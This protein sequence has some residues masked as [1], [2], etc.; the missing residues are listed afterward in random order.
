M[1]FTRY[2]SSM[3]GMIT[4]RPAVASDS[5]DLYEW[6]NDPDSRGA[7]GSQ[8]P[9]PRAE[10]DI[11]FSAAISSRDRIIY[12][13]VDSGSGASVGMCR[14]DIDRE[15]L[16]A[17]VSI[18]LDPAR[19]GAGL[20]YPI[21]DG[22]IARFRMD[23]GSALRLTATIRSTNKASARIFRKAGFVMMPSSSAPFDQYVLV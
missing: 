10:H 1:T 4:F 13:A 15:A 14:F 12:L 6:R 20:A 18:N 2:E 21:L 16:T 22:A 17:E 11:W 3:G 23:S 5:E 7:S 9:V 19:R 8:K